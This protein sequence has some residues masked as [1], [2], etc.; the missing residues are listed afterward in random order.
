MGVAVFYGRQDELAF[1]LVSL[2]QPFQQALRRDKKLTAHFTTAVH[3][4]E[5]LPTIIRLENLKGPVSLEMQR[6]N[7][8][9]DA[10][11]FSGVGYPLTA[12]LTTHLESTLQML[13]Q[14]EIPIKFELQLP[15][16]P[17]QTPSLPTTAR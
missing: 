15:G 7:W 17:I 12:R 4:G 1:L 6:E 11:I 8:V 5:V 13:Y 9:Y 3:S 16:P 2:V 10:P 14:N